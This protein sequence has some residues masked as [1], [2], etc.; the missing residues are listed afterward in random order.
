MMKTF[1]RTDIPQFGDLIGILSLVGAINAVI[2]LKNKE[3]AGVKKA[4]LKL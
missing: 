3:Y 2:H 4:K 1:T